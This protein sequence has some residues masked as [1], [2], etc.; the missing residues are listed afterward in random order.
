[1]P[2]RLV[3]H[4][5]RTRRGPHPIPRAFATQRDPRTIAGE[6]RDEASGACRAHDGGDTRAKRREVHEHAVAAH[7][8]E[9]PEQVFAEIEGVALLEVEPAADRRGERRR[10]VPSDF[11]QLC[12]GVDPD[13]VV[14]PFR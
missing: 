5:G 8:V 12:R 7:Q 2:S 3:E 6:Q 14:T 1:M 10:C 4:R 13:D 11:Q 9:A